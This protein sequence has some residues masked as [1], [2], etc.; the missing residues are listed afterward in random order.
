MEVVVKLKSEPDVQIKY[1]DCYPS[2]STDTREV[3]I[4]DLEDGV[5][6]IYDVE[7]LHEEVVW[8]L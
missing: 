8:K 4:L 5:Q 1:Q 3:L 6:A 7:L 2:Y